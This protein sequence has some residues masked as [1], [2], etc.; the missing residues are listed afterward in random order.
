MIKTSRQL[1]NCL[2]IS[3]SFPRKID[4]SG[5]AFGETV[6]QVISKQSKGFDTQ[7]VSKEKY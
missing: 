7:F 2:E 1:K 5:Q 3:W 6:E 4:V